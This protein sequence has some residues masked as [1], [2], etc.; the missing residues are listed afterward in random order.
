MNETTSRG[1][2]SKNV[3]TLLLLRYF[4]ENK[5]LLFYLLVF[6]PLT[7]LNSPRSRRGSMRLLD[8][9]LTRLLSRLL[10]LR[11]LPL[12]HRRSLTLPLP[13]V[14]EVLALRRLSAL[15]PLRSTRR[16]LR[17]PVRLPRHST[18]HACRTTTTRSRR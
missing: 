3:T 7:L 18:R 16:R 5:L 6:R 9:H 13:L 10:P 12:L 11:L 15:E 8:H 4:F 2:R 17:G 14:L 1:K